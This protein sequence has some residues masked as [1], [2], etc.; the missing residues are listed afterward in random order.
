[1]DS[2]QHLS[3]PRGRVPGVQENDYPAR[4]MVLNRTLIRVSRTALPSKWEGA[5]REGRQDTRCY[6]QPAFL[7][8]ELETAHAHTSSTAAPNDSDARRGRGARPPRAC[9]GHYL[10]HHRPGAARRKLQYSGARH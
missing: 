1:M 5:L 4:V 8:L 9:P 10:F 7:R 6:T 3:G 2:A